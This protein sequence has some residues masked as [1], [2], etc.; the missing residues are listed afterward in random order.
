MKIAPP[1]TKVSALVILGAI[2]I[3]L[4][5]SA[6][7]TK[8]T[9]EQ[10]QEE[11]ILVYEKYFYEKGDGYEVHEY[12]MPD[13]RVGYQYIEYAEDGTITSTGYGPEAKDRTFVI[14]STID[15]ASTSEG[16]ID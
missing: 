11:Q 4:P 7:V 3:T 12:Q 1:I 8:E 14:E 5:V 16:S 10:R 15:I 2:L 6:A 9:I 13:S